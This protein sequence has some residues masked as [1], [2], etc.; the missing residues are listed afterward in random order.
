MRCCKNASCY[1]SLFSGRPWF[2]TQ[3]S[4]PFF[5]SVLY[6]VPGTASSSVIV[7]NYAIAPIN[8]PYISLLK[9]SLM[10]MIT[11]MV[12]ADHCGSRLSDLSS[13][14]QIPHSRRFPA[15]LCP[16]G[17]P[18]S[19][20]FLLSRQWSPGPA[21]MAVSETQ[22]SCVTMGPEARRA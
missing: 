11:D 21:S 10:V 13:R 9:Y 2:N 16:P 22:P 17:R 1:S 4:T 19:R 14:F 6:R 15:V 5:F 8:H 7:S 12:E 18:L 3:H 20:S